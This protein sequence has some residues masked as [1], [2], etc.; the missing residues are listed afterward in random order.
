MDDVDTVEVQKTAF[1]RSER[2]REE[3]RE[4][5]DTVGDVADV[6]G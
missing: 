5:V 6:I 1:L 4:A 2:L 3:R